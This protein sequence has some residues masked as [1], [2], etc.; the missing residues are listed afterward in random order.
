MNEYR[1]QREAM[2]EDGHQTERVLRHPVLIG[3]VLFDV[4][5]GGT[6]RLGGAPFNVAWH[7]AGFGY[8]PRFISRVGDDP[9][10]REI[11]AT[12]AEWG[13]A[14][15]DIQVDPDAPTGE[16]RITGGGPNQPGYEIV[17]DQAFDRISPEIEPQVDPDALL[18]H[19][20]LALRG[21]ATRKAVAACVAAG[22]PVF[23]DCNLR[24]PWWTASAVEGIV[25]T[26]RW[27]KL[28]DE[29]LTVV[30]TALGRAAVGRTAAEG[31]EELRQL[32][33]LDEV[34]VTIGSDG[35]LAATGSGGVRVEAPQVEVL[36]SVGAGD[37]LSAV[38]IAG[39]LEGWS[40]E[41]RLERAAA[42]AARVCRVRGALIHDRS[43]Y[44]T[45]IQNWKQDS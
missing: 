3:E 2:G 33:D 11:L 20:T 36:D 45:F 41:S 17:P 10:G 6:R 34:V 13:M 43:V 15:D 4:F 16:V 44:E 18:Y 8:R 12:M 22:G 21:V 40:L 24:P 42:F 37:A 38:V 27:L 29:E 5:E 14:T 9:A 39:L 28:N 7:L 25:T 26:A 35:A 31:A 23:V 19:G 30:L 32:A 1:Q